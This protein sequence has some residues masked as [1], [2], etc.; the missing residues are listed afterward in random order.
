MRARA[1]PFIALVVVFV[2]V[3]CAEAGGGAPSAGRAV[4]TLPSV[5]QRR[6]GVSIVTAAGDICTSSPTSCA[7]T[8]DLIRTLDP[9]AA[10]TL[11]DNQYSDGSLAEYL[12]SYDQEWGTFKDVTFPVAGNHEWHTPDA[13][14]FLDYFGLDGYWYSFTLGLWRIYALDGTCSADGGCGLGDPQYRWLKRKLAAR[15]DRCIL[16]YWHQPR[17]SSGTNH[18]SDQEVAPLWRLLYRARADLILNGHEHNYERFAPQNPAG[19]PAPEGIVQIVAGTGGNGEG[20]YP[21]GDPVANSEVRLNGLGVVKLTL[22][23]HGWVERFIR[24]SGEVVD[25]SSGTC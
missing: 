3:S 13:Q 5:H 12:D 9:D 17:F 15:A 23:A 8:A 14:G 11:G 1:V 24:P 16:A 19:G 18:G 4:S 6:P 10:L 21:F 25:R 22:R 2:A 20:S 7:P